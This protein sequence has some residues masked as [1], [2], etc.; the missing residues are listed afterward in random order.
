MEPITRAILLASPKLRNIKE[1]CT[2]VRRQK[3][4]LGTPQQIHHDPPPP[5]PPQSQRS[6]P[7]L[8]YPRFLLQHRPLLP[9]T[10]P[11]P[12]SSLQPINSP[13]Q[14]L[15]R[16]LSHLSTHLHDT[17]NLRRHSRNRN[18]RGTEEETS[19]ALEE[20]DREERLLSPV[21]TSSAARVG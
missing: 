10:H 13:V 5:P 17:L 6:A 18:N 16:P 8:Q 2:R 7:N 21:R 3:D 1:S 20:E 15:K 14:N 4:M 11:E 9:Y 19:R 12:Q